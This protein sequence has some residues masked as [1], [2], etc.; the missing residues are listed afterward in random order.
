[1]HKHQIYGRFFIIRRAPTNLSQCKQIMSQALAFFLRSWNLNETRERTT[2]PLKRRLTYKFVRCV[3]CK[4]L[5]LFKYIDLV[6]LR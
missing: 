5:Q 6:L 2:H 4:A 3:S 1:M